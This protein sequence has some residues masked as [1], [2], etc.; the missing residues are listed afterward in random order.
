METIPS[1]LD[2]LPYLVVNN[3]KGSHLNILPLCFVV[4]EFKK[5]SELLETLIEWTF[6]ALDFD[7]ISCQKQTNYR[8]RLMKAGMRLAGY[9]C[10][11]DTDL[12]NKMLVGI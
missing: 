5:F 2:G 12:L 11:C 3:N 4:N 8:L 7:T 10:T 6:E 1:L 9:F